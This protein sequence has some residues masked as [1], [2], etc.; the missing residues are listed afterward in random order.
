MIL[1][2]LCNTLVWTLWKSVHDSQCLISF[3]I[4]QPCFLGCCPSSDHPE[5]ASLDCRRSTEA[6]RCLAR[7]CWTTSALSERKIWKTSHQILKV[8]LSSH[9][10]VLSL[11]SPESPYFLKQ[12]NTTSW[13]S[14]V[15][16]FPLKVASL[17]QNYDFMPNFVVI[18]LEWCGWKL[19]M[20]EY[21][22]QLNSYTMC[23]KWTELFPV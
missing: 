8:F 11:T 23:T 10:F 21:L 5:G 1:H 14:T 4:S 9:S 20:Y 6:A 16:D 18:W 13:V 19:I 15:A 12:L 22:L 17:L 2:C 7:S 3:S